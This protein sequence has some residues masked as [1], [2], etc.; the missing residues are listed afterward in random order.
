MRGRGGEQH[1]SAQSVRLARR[2]AIAADAPSA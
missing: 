2:A 1:G